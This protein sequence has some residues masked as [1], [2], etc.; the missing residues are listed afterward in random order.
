MKCS[1]LHNKI[2]LPTTIP[3]CL[4]VVGVGVSSKLFLARNS[5][6]CSENYNK[7]M[8]STSTPWRWGVEG[9]V[10]KNILHE[11]SNLYK[12]SC[13]TPLPWWGWIWR[14]WKQIENNFLSLGSTWNVLVCAET[15]CFPTTSLLGRVREVRD[16]VESNFFAKDCINVLIYTI[17][18][19]FQLPPHGSGSHVEKSVFAINFMKCLDL[20]R[21]VMFASYHPQGDC[22][23]SWCSN[24]M[25][26]AKNCI[27]CSDLH[28]KVMLPT[29]TFI[30]IGACLVV[31]VKC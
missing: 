21:K 16:E 5:M 20:H 6:K 18:T 14:V 29:T 13:L 28:S 27:N 31:G 26:F 22:I 9:Q 23:E 8:F 2:M 3:W 24:K 17:K 10:K 19:C 4:G 11:S 7:V 1:D 25:H 15:S 30:G 12:E